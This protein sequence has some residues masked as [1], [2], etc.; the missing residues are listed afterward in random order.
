MQQMLESMA[1]PVA[2]GFRRLK[3]KFQVRREC[4][5]CGWRGHAFSEGGASHKLRYDCR[6]PK[7]R[8]AERHRLAFMVA[9]S[10]SDLDFSAVLH[11]APERGLSNYL[12]AKATEYLSIDLHNEAMA[13]MDITALDLPDHSQSLVWISHV[14]E[15]IE[16]DFAAISEMHRVLRPSGVAFVQVPI[17]RTV[18]YEDASITDQSDRL[19][20]FFQKD[21]VRLYGLDIVERFESNGFTASVHR[22]QDFGP[23]ALLR[24]GLSFASTDEVFVFRKA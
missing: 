11:V 14:L 17:W 10:L 18:T 1:R 4:P 24:Y 7:C 13:R 23:E 15:H 6:C 22:A 21:H 12:R 2:G 8:S 16:D 9:E 5:I 3:S 19:R 20:H